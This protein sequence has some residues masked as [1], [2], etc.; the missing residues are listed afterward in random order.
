[1]HD[2]KSLNQTNYCPYTV[3][4]SLDQRS[5]LKAR[6]AKTSFTFGNKAQENRQMESLYTSEI[7]AQAKKGGPA[8]DGRDVQ[9]ALKRSN[10]TIG[11]DRPVNGISEAKTQFV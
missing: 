7:D 11:T 4:S 6:M 8:A 3:Q 5:E 10:F 9:L 1:M 2:G